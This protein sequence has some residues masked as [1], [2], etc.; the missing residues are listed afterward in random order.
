MMKTGDCVKLTLSWGHGFRPV[1]KTGI[2]QDVYSNGMINV[3]I[4]LCHGGYRSVW[5]STKDCVPAKK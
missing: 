4:P 1:E 3:Q 5:G 2:I